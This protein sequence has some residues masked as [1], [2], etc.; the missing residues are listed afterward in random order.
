MESG[1]ILT[2]LVIATLL[3]VIGARVIAYRYR[4]SMQRLMK[5]PLNTGLTAGSGI[6]SVTQEPALAS[7]GATAGSA[8]NFPPRT[9]TSPAALTLADNRRAH[10]RL[11]V[12]FLAL[13]LVMALTR[14]LITQ[15]SADAPITLKTV[16]TLGAAYAWPLLP[17][18]AVISR[19]SRPRFVGAMLGWFV[20]AVL[21]LT[22]RTNENI[23]FAQVVD[24]MFFDT[25]CRLSS[26]PPSAWAGRRAPSGRGW[27]PCSC[28]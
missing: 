24:W 8:L 26:S 27:R 25:A 15:V 19:W 21:L 9:T 4:A 2:V 22:W 28:C 3:A 10:R 6:A 5:T 23:S 18:L 11:L 20:L 1:K 14:T 16:A 13:T 7:I 12:S 17:V